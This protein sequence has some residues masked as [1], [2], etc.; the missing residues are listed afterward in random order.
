MEGDKVDGFAESE[1]SDSNKM[2]G[3]I[4]AQI[5]PVESP[6]LAIEYLFQRCWLGRDIESGNLF[7][8]SKATTTKTDMG[9]VC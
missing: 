3:A 2:R 7:L 5:N 9:V 1:K 4:D 6:A 8:P